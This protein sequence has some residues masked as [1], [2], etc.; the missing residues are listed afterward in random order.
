MRVLKVETCLV[1]EFGLWLGSDRA[2]P[3]SSSEGKTICT[4]VTNVYVPIK[5]YSWNC[6]NSMFTMPHFLS[7]HMLSPFSV[8]YKHMACLLFLSFRLF[9]SVFKLYPWLLKAYMLDFSAIFLHHMFKD[10][11]LFAKP[12]KL[13]CIIQHGVH[14][15]AE[16][17]AVN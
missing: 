8:C 16:Y 17:N 12:S 9:V 14:V 1:L 7:S 6:I 5:V 11:I 4:G 13:P 3:L 2:V 10:F 15:K